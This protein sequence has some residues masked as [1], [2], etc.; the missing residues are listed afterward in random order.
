M[1]ALPLLVSISLLLILISAVIALANKIPRSL[2]L[3]DTVV[4]LVGVTVALFIWLGIL[5][6][7]NIPINQAFAE[8]FTDPQWWYIL[9]LLLPPLIFTAI[10]PLIP[11]HNNV[12][13]EDENYDE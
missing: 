7:L 1:Y 5:Y 6:F 11:R 8:I 9:V 13:E 10:D 12:A 2:V 3:L 4:T